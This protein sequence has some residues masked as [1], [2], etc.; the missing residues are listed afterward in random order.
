VG[1]NGGNYIWFL[2]GHLKVL[3]RDSKDS[4]ILA[5]HADEGKEKGE[6]VWLTKESYEAGDML[7]IT[8]LTSEGVGA[9][10]QF[11]LGVK[12]HVS[13]LGELGAQGWSGSMG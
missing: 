8:L 11:Q 6:R 4:P 7:F 5:M 9:R 13:T 10:R 12:K 1:S 3:C 2:D